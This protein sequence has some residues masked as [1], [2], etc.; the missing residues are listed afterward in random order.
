VI[1][2]AIQHGL[3][4]S[5]IATLEATEFIRDLDPRRR[6]SA[7]DTLTKARDPKLLAALTV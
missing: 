4:S 6:Q 3:P 5:W 7:V 2:G 1:A